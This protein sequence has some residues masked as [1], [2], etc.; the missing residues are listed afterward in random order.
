MTQWR[1]QQNISAGDLVRLAVNQNNKYRDI[2]Q[3]IKVRSR[4]LHER[5]GLE[6]LERAFCRYDILEL[7][8]RRR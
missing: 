3:D 4:R 7:F 5:R 6:I 1:R 2:F 8:S